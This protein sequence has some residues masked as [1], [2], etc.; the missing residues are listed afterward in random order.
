MK[1]LLDVNVLIAGIWT[2][3]DQHAVALRWLSGKQIVL[4]PLTELGFMRIS[5][6][7]KVL[8]ATMDRTRELLARF[9]ADAN[10][11]RVPADLAALDSR[12]R[13]SAQVTDH[14]LADLAAKHGLKLATLDGQLKHPAVEV[15]R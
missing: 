8:N 6:N 4:C 1:Y 3:H 10:A 13:T 5:T 2:S 7:K 15:V 11:D 12:P 9:A 14:Y